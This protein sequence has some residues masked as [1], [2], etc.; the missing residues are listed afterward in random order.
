MAAARNLVFSRSYSYLE[1]AYILHPR[2]HTTEPDKQLLALTK[3]CLLQEP[4]TEFKKYSQALDTTPW[5]DTI[6]KNTIYAR[7][8]DTQSEFTPRGY[9]YSLFQ[10]IV[11]A[12]FTNSTP[13]LSEIIRNL[14]FVGN[15]EAGGTWRVMGRR[16]G[17]HGSLK[18]TLVKSKKES[19]VFFEQNLVKESEKWDP[20][21]DDETIFS[22]LNTRNVRIEKESAVSSFFDY[23]PHVHTVVLIDSRG[24]SENHLIQRAVLTLHALLV[25]QTKRKYDDLGGLE[26]LPEP[27]CAQGIVTNGKRFSFIWYQ[28]NTTQFE[29]LSSGVKNLLAIEKPGLLYSKITRT[30]GGKSHIY[31][32]LE[33]YN[34]DI[35]KT[36]LSMFLWQQ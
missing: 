32:V 15:C 11:K 2:V 10:N 7:N 30:R 20:F 27:V 3:S 28:L 31:R 12:L 6:R 18:G 34:D 33:E 19:P 36:L 22:N 26:I 24:E 1:P 9:P 5:S 4:P 35:L 17:V 14:H 29:D 23:F 13:E 21:C 16:I 25:E 8:F